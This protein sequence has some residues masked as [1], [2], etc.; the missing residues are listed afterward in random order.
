MKTTKI[1]SALILLLSISACGGNE[2][3]SQIEATGT[4]ESTNVTISSKNVGEIKSIIADE[5]T[6]V[7]A[8]DTILVIDH[9]A[10]G[11]Q[12]LQAEASEKIAEAQLNL[13]LKGARSE[14]INQA[15]EMMKQ[16]ETNYKLAKNDFD[17][18]SK[19]WESKS[20][21]QKQ[22]EDITARYQIA[23][24]QYSASKENFQKV[25]KIF[26]PEEIEQARGNA[27]K[28]K[29]S[30]GLLKKNISDSYIIAPLDGFVVKKFVEVGETVSPMSSLVKVSNLSSV[31][32]IIYISELELGK[33]KLGQK[34]EITI[35]TYPDKKYHGV[36][37]Y[38][39]PEAE[40]T[41]KNIQTK[42]ERTK[43]VFA[44]KIEIPNKGFELKPGMPADAIILL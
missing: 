29:A 26:R 22:Y 4:I 23:L 43:L 13:M 11:F 6:K 27:Q 39:S 35:D 44:V 30:V 1:I 10:L 38:I 20:I 5:G 41:P 37:T 17:R 32:L 40:F 9:E 34:A 24:A 7:N 2:D 33:V 8:G 31:N 18:Y 3:A 12:L 19:L 15:E 21:T 36:V 14:D 42:D 25:K 16:S 28:A